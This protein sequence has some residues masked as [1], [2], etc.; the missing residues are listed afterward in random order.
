MAHAQTGTGTGHGGTLEKEQDQEAFPGP[1]FPVSRRA[2]FRLPAV[3]PDHGILALLER[4]DVVR[5][6]VVRDAPVLGG[7]RDDALGRR[8]HQGPG[9]ASHVAAPA[10]LGLLVDGP[11]L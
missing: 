9:L 1:V 11:A 6:E 5:Q 2:L 3:L 8:V 4:G 10:V 7:T